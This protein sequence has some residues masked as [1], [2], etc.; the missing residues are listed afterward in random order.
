MSK[1]P[2]SDRLIAK[3]KSWGDFAKALTALTKKEKGDCFE[4]LT[5]ALSVD[6]TLGA[7]HDR[8][9]RKESYVKNFRPLHS[10]T[11]EALRVRDLQ[12]TSYQTA[13]AS[14]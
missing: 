14:K 1:N 12:P 10:S 7:E 5:P 11:V 2:K 13:G 6:Q 4:R 9:K 8:F 3:C